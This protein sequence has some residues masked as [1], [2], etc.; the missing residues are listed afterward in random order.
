AGTNDLKLNYMVVSSIIED[1]NQ[2]LWIGTEGGGINFYDIKSGRFQYITHQSGNA[3]SLSTN[4]VK[5]MIRSSDGHFWIGTHDGGLNVLN[6]AKQPYRF[7]T[8]VNNPNDS[9]SLSSNRVI[10]LFEDARQ[11]IW[12]GTSG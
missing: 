4:N 9:T 2:N 12:I 6:S 8:F 3:N 10:S 7:K 5:A 11:D 1:P